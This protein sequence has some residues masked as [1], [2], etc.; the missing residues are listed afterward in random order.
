MVCTEQVSYK[1]SWTSEAT[2]E[3]W[4]ENVW[5]NLKKMF[6]TKM[7]LKNDSKTQNKTF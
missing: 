4:L 5:R 2:A 3:K 7:I 1:E 6:Q